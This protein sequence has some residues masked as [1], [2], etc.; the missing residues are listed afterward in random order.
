MSPKWNN[1]GGNWGQ[2][3]W[4]T[5]MGAR[6]TKPKNWRCPPCGFTGNSAHWTWCGKCSTE[7]TPATPADT[8]GRLSA[9]D[10]ANDAAKSPSDHELDDARAQLATLVAVFPPGHAYIDE[11]AAK[12]AKLESENVTHVSTAD[13]L[14][15][16]LADAT[17]LKKQKEYADTAVT[18][19]VKAVESATEVLQKKV[20]ACEDATA[21]FNANTL[22]I[23]ELTRPERIETIAAD[24]TPMQALRAQIE[25]I[26]P[27]KLAEQ[28]IPGSDLTKFFSIFNVLMSAMKAAAPTTATTT[29][30][31]P[32]PTP[33]PTPAAVVEPPRVFLTTAP[34]LAPV[35]VTAPVVTAPAPDPTPAVAPAAAVVTQAAPAT[36]D[37]VEVADIPLGQEW[38][39][40]TQAEKRIREG[41]EDADGDDG[42]EDE[43]TRLRKTAAPLEAAA[44]ALKK[45]KVA[46]AG[47]A[48]TIEESKLEPDATLITNGG[49]SG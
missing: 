26:T 10:L 48:L 14:R 1:N 19:A 7:W 27:E 40:E 41:A 43:E 17:K 18:A 47:A 20:K 35:E 34:V 33:I 28:G 2:H 22:E 30:P 31:P 49:S 46:L 29:E 37:V 24:V 45:V 6:P 32:T 42:M 8:A 5:G 25:T 21:S 38:K 23:A 4:S 36:A 9:K 12:V 11:Y 13:R 15:A 39:M 16:L 44:S 3:A